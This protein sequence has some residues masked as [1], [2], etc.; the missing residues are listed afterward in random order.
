[1]GSQHLW[2]E[3]VVVKLHKNPS[4]NLNMINE[5][6]DDIV[7]IF[8][9]DLRIPNPTGFPFDCPG[10]FSAKDDWK[11]VLIFGMSFIHYLTL[12]SL[13][14]L[15]VERHQRALEFEPVKGME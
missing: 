15:P 8:E 2:V 6:I 4:P 1:M 14:L 7:D 3:K 10:H 13:D 12:E 5:T 11:A 9:Q